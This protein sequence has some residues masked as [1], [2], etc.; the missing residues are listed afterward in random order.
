MQN[1]NEKLIEAT[2]KLSKETLCKSRDTVEKLTHPSKNVSSIGS[3][4]GGTVGVGL[5][6][7]GTIRLLLGSSIWGMSSLV[8]GAATVASNAVNM[9][10]IKK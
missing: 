5:I 1:Y 9:K 2:K 6:L 8:A 10:K 7:V 3:T 4:I